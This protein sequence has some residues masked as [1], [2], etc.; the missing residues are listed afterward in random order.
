MR[1]GRRHVGQK[2]VFLH[3]V[4]VSEP[5]LFVSLAS[6]VFFFRSVVIGYEG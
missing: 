2:E 3:V 1:V 6:R 5:R 4:A